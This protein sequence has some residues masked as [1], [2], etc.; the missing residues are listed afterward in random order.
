[1]NFLN[2]LKNFLISFMYGRYGTDN[3]YNF[4]TVLTLAIIVINL[5]LN[6]FIISLICLALIFWNLFR[7]LSKNR[8]KRQAENRIYLKIKGKLLSP[9]KK[10][11]GRAKE[12][13]ALAKAKKRD[14]DTHVFIKCPSCKSTLRLPKVKGD[15]KV[16]CPRCHKSFDVRI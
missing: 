12:R 7:S 8:A 11:R 14:K 10:A 1:M 9:F 16:G 15:H 2:K 6:S 13:S 5:F 4:L 3:L